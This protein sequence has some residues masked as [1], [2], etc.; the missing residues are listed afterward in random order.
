[1]FDLFVDP[2]R[3]NQ[4]TLVTRMSFLTARL[5]APLLPPALLRVRLL[6]LLRAIARRRQRGVARVLPEVLASGANPG[7]G[8]LADVRPFLGRQRRSRWRRKRPISLCIPPWHDG[9]LANAKT[10]HQ[11]LA[12]KKSSGLRAPLVIGCIRLDYVWLRTFPTLRFLGGCCRLQQPPATCIGQP[13]PFLLR[14]RA[15]FRWSF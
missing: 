14:Q 3:G 8:S 15:P 10:W 2:L 4:R 13:V 6:L 1:V 9:T 7:S 12:K 5:S 11:T